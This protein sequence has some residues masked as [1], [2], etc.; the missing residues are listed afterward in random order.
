MSGKIVQPKTMTLAEMEADITADEAA[1]KAEMENTA[2][3]VTPVIAT[4]APAEP[5][6]PQKVEPPKEEPP[7]ESPT[8]TPAPVEPVI[9]EVEVLKTQIA[10]LT[11]RVRDEDGKRG[12][13]LAR[14]HEQINVLNNQNR[15]NL[16][17]LEELRKAKA[18]PEIPPE[19]DPLEKEYPELA[20]GMDRR[21]KPA[22]DVANEAILKTRQLEEKTQRLEADLKR[23]E[24]DDFY[25]KVKSVVPN[26]EE[27]NRDPKFIEWCNGRTPG[28]DK[29]R[30]QAFKRYA[31]SR[32]AEPVIELY[33]Q[34]IG[35][36]KPASTETAP[37]GPAKPSKEAQVQVPTSIAPA[38]KATTTADL[39][40]RVK[41]LEDKCYKLK[42]AT[43]DDWKEYYRSL[44]ELERQ[45]QL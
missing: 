38:A 4:P 30:Q 9:S 41:Q 20:N 44:D 28:D 36:N 35:Q 7:K 5:I 3:T 34:W 21:V 43:E 31:D 11:K 19:P 17:K 22:V 10:E 2:N 24:W 13:E 27:I 25:N 26:I 37:K 16:L 40:R 15:E 42:S 32:N 45:G 29:S 1:I 14:L 8:A 18:E 12:G 39:Q 23:R 33:E 6:D